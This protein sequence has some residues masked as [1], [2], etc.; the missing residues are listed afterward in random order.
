VWLFGTNDDAPEDLRMDV[1][2]ATLVYAWHPL[3]EGMQRLEG[4]E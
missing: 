4:G 2:M 3:V 1:F